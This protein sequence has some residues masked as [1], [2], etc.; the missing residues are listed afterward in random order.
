MNKAISTTDSGETQVEL[1]SRRHPESHFETESIRIEPASN[2][3]FTVS[4]HKKL[5]KKFEGMRHMEGSWREP[6]KLVFGSANELHGH[7]TSLFKPT[8]SDV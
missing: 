2:G 3:G 1:P 6:D 5:K 7:L 4:H 8:K